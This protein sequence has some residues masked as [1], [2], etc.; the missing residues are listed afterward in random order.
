MSDYLTVQSSQEGREWCGTFY[1][2]EPN[3]E[4]ILFSS[5]T[6]VSWNKITACLYFGV[7]FETVYNL[8]YN[9]IKDRI[10]F[11]IYDNDN[12]YEAYPNN[13]GFNVPGNNKEE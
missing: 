4:Y 10:I 8:L 13:M 5:V 7:P 11:D 2:Y 6:L 3:S 1:Y 12:E 9:Q